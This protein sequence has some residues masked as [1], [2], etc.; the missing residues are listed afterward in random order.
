MNGGRESEIKRPRI[1][2]E[3]TGAVKNDNKYVWGRCC[4]FLPHSL[5]KCKIHPHEMSWVQGI[6]DYHLTSSYKLL[7]TSQVSEFIRLINK[8]I[9]IFISLC[10]RCTNTSAF[11][12]EIYFLSVLSVAMLRGFVPQKTRFREKERKTKR[13]KRKRKRTARRRVNWRRPMTNKK[14]KVKVYVSRRQAERER[15]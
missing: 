10:N 3:N 14:V 1:N 8:W 6:L 5:V 2:T 11:T 12:D 7:Q 9:F 15:K 4:T 13:K